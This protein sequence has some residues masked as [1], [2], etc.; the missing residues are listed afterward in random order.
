M[1]VVV[2]VV[3]ALT[4]VP[5]MYVCMICMHVYL[6]Q[7]LSAGLLLAFVFFKVLFFFGVLLCLTFLCLRTLFMTSGFLGCGECSQVLYIHV[8]TYVCNG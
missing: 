2:V 4:C 1:V 6:R 8:C 3:A 7:E 5:A